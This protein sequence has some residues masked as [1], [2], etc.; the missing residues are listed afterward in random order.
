M[1]IRATEP[2]WVNEHLAHIAVATDLRACPAKRHVSRAD[3]DVVEQKTAI[4]HEV[5]L[6]HYV[7]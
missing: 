2:R 6:G 4:T 5:E 1:N 3:N 7:L